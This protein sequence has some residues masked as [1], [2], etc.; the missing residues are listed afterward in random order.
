MNELLRASAFHART[1]AANR[2]NAWVT[3]SGV[4]LACVYTSVD[5]EALVARTRVALADRGGRRQLMLQGPRV[6][7]FL[8]RLLTRDT[9]GVLPGSA[10][11]A[12][13]LADGGGVRGAA[14]IARFG[15]EAFWLLSASP[16]VAWIRAAAALFDVHL[17]E[18]SA[19]RSGLAIIGPYA[20]ATLENAG[21]DANL[22]PLAFRN[23][24]WRGLE[25]IVSRFGEHGGYELWCEP[26]DAILVWDRVVQAGMPYAIAPIGTAAM[27]VLDVEAG[28]P[29]PYRD[30]RPAT[31]ANACEPS[32]RRLGLESLMDP[33]HAAF[34]GR[35]AYLRDAKQTTPR[36]MGV[37]IDSDR[38]APHT[39]LLAGG[40]GIGHTLSSCYSPTLR[41]AIALARIE[42]SAAKAGSRLTVTLPPGLAWP[43]LRVVRATV[44][45]LPFLGAP[46]FLAG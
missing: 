27:E 1:A 9:D 3:R 36:W 15:K 12:L 2:S 44:V 4:T 6:V 11:K 23:A 39:P 32:P 21:L 41:R 46:D 43:E 26:D 29:R 33:E 10:I 37:E 24:S 22:Q 5:E 30:Y 7:E 40:R 42:E 17:R 14:A 25:V 31:E 20:N 38:A 34:N 45:D 35:T 19:E 18:I 28:I 16:D 8:Q 13:W